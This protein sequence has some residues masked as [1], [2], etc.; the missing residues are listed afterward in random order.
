MHMPE[1][2]IFKHRLSE[3]CNKATERRFRRIDVKMAARCGG[4][5]LIIEGG[6]EEDRVDNL[7]EFQYLGRT[8]DQIDYYWMAVRQNI[9][10]AR[11]F[12]GGA[13]DTA[14]TGRGR[15]QGGG[16]VLQ[17]GGSIDTPV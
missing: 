9:M 16:N 5:K 15:P 2:N 8:L 13:G 12:W 4:M 6:E 10:R 17:G 11:S 3:K 14:L 1:A 7:T